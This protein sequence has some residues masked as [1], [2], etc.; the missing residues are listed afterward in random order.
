MK[1]VKNTKNELL[2]QINELQAQLKVA[3]EET[4]RLQTQLG[5]LSQEKA[6]LEQEIKEMGDLE[7]GF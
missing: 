6:Q 1:T 7:E 5:E 4:E 3:T 2:N